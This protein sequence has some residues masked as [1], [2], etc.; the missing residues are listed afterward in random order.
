[1]PKPKSGISQKQIEAARRRRRVWPFVDPLNPRGMVVLMKAWLDSMRVKGHSER[2]V[3][4]GEWSVSDFIVFC[5][6]RDIV[7]ARDVTK[8]VIERY[9]KTLFYAR[10]EDGSPLTLSTQSARLSFLKQYF[11]WLLRENHLLSNPA[12]GIE[13]PKVEKRLPK[14][15]LTDAEAE[16]ILM[17]PDLGTPLGI[18]DRA[19]LETLYSTGVRRSE[20][21]RLRLQ[22][23]DLERGTVIVRQGKGRKDRLIPIGARALAWLDRYVREVRPGYVVEPDDG[24]LFLSHW[25]G[26][27]SPNNLCSLVSRHVHA[28]GLTHAGG[29]HLFRHAMATLMLENGAD[30]RFIQ[31]MLGHVKLTTTEIYTH[32]SIKKLKEIHTATHPSARL[33]P[34]KR[35]E[36]DEER[37]LGSDDNL[38]GEDLGDVERG[39]TVDEL[40]EQV[41]GQAAD[42]AGG[43]TQEA[44]GPVIGEGQTSGSERPERAS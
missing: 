30:I 31:A 5:Q 40:T 12:S 43:A 2:T 14:H 4:S 23:I 17:Q 33:E 11:K 37:V 39:R 41:P 22:D 24:R 18:R 19:L 8:P 25:G 26:P 42:E 20:L 29:C 6:E 35:H 10:K 3:W 38:A 1:M 21:G 16:A 13:L 34:P 44:S 15:I 9:Q 32:I 28:S 36:G 7:L 27:L